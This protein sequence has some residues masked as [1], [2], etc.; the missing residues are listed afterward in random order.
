MKLSYRI[1][2]SVFVVFII[3]IFFWAAFSPKEDLSVKIQRTLKEQEKVADLTFKDVSFEEVLGGIKYWQ[4]NAVSALINKST[5]VAALRQSNGNFFKSGKATLRFLSPAAV[6]DMKKKQ[7]LL[8]QPFGYDINLQAKVDQLM[9]QTDGFQGSFFNLPQLFGQTESYWFKAKNLSWS[10]A[11]EKLTCTGGIILKKGEVTGLAKKLTGDVALEHVW[12]T[13][14]P[15][16]TIALE[17]DTIIT[18]EADSFQID[19]PNNLITAHGSPV[20]HWGEAIITAGKLQYQQ[21]KNMLRLD[22]QVKIDY[23]DIRGWGKSGEYFTKSQTIVLTGKARAIQ[24]DN[25]LTGEK[26]SVSLGDK[27]IS[28]AGRGKVVITE[29]DLPNGKKEQ[30]DDNNTG[31]TEN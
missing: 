10:L 31:Q 1:L 5:G 27:K 3:G 2:L 19:T 29:N 23:N 28:V 4:L 24:G 15:I 20:I 25:S 21:D 14:A 8:D 22:D 9:K 6:W 13:G 30:N 17:D 16:I 11:D 7:I 12:L 26:I 18:I